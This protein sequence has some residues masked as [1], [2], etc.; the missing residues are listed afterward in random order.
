MIVFDLLYSAKGELVLLNNLAGSN[1]LLTALN[2]IGLGRKL[3]RYCY[4]NALLVMPSKS[5]SNIAFYYLRFNIRN[6]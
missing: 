4:Y 2:N 5:L 3:T 1:I 6:V